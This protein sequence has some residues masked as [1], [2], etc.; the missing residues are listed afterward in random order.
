MIM[1]LKIVYSSLE[2]GSLVPCRTTQRSTEVRQEAE[3]AR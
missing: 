2:V 3:G 1:K